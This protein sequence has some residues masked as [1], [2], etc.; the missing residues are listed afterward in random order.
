M[1]IH[2][3]KKDVD[4][5]FF[6]TSFRIHHAP[7]PYICRH[8]AED[9]WPS[10]THVKVVH[11]STLVG[12]VFRHL[13]EPLSSSRLRA[14]SSGMS[15]GD[16]SVMRD[17]SIIADDHQAG[18]WIGQCSTAGIYRFIVKGPNAP[19]TGYG[20]IMESNHT[21]SVNVGRKQHWNTL[22]WIRRETLVKYSE[23][24]DVTS[25]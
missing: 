19:R 1:P 22:S 20:L 13:P 12:T 21:L 24:F 18:R 3:P 16:S 23:S 4:F 5:D 25:Y 15:F 8:L 14:N 6:K 10:I 11:A 9:T 17:I 7:S 2:T